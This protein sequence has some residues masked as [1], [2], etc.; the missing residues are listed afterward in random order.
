MSQRF[1]IFPDRD[2]WTI[3]ER[4]IRAAEAN[5]TVA[6]IEEGGATCVYFAGDPDVLAD[7][8]ELPVP[9]LGCIRVLRSESAIQ[10]DAE[11]YEGS[12]IQLSAFVRAMLRAIGPCKVFDD[13]TG[14]DLTW[15]ADRFPSRLLGPEPEFDDDDE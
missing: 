4:V 1:T 12:A 5:P 9:N 15:Q 3:A 8:S 2:F 10:V 14:D 11:G 7:A 13:E 6:V